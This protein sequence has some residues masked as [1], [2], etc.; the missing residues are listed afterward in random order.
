ME[1]LYSLRAQLRSSLTL[2][3]AA[4]RLVLV[5]HTLVISFADGIAQF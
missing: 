3:S 5:I 2:E 1:K 4:L